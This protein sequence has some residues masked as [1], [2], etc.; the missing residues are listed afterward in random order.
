MLKDSSLNIKALLLQVGKGNQAAF[1]AVFDFYKERF[2]SACFKMTKSGDVAEEIVQEV[3]ISLWV[4]RHQV[5]AAANPEAYLLTI[6]HNSIYAH[7]RKLALEKTLKKK[8]LQRSSPIEISPVEDMLLAK[9][10]Y[11]MLEAVISQLPPQQRI[12]YKLCRQQ[13]LTREQIATQLH[14]SPHTVKNHLQEAIK[15]IRSYY[16][17]DAS[18][19][20][21]IAIWLCI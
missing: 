2:Y 7:F 19:F 9:E 14:I 17:L 20:I 16:K 6:L 5:A 13:G 1:K 4:K 18:A 12:V 3:F 21:W 11:Q 15:F 8:I 10:N